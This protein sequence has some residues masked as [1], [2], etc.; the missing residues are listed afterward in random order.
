MYTAVVELLPEIEVKDYKGLKLKGQK[1]A[2]TAGDIKNE[3]ERLRTVYSQ[4]K[5]AEGRA[6]VQEGD[7]LLLDFQG[8]F[9]KKPIRDGKVE[10]YTLEVGSDAMVPGFEAALVGKTPGVEH[11]IHVTMPTDHPRKDLAGKN[12]EFLVTIKEIKEKILPALDDEFAKDVGN[13]NDLKELKKKI[14]THFL[15]L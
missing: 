14:K 9:D 5:T 6:T 2:V 1:T 8:F 13:Y 12:I 15:S 10:D 3:L 7:V 11:E 4:L